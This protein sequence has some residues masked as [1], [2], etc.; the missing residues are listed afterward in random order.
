MARTTKKVDDPVKANQHESYKTFSII[1][2]VIPLVGFILGIVYLT[3]DKKL[4]KKL[5]EHLLVLSIVFSFIWWFLL[6]T[7]VYK[8]VTTSVPV[9]TTSSKE[10]SAKTTPV[11]TPSTV[12][13][14]SI[15]KLGGD[16][17]LSVT[18]QQ[19]VDPASSGNQYITP[20]SGKRFVAVMLQITNN[21]HNSYSDDAYLN[22]KLIGTDNQ[23]A[24][25]S[26]FP[27]SECTNF[28]NGS[29]TLSSGSS[30]TGCIP[31]QLTDGVNVAKV[32][33]Q[34]NG[35]FYGD[36]AEWLAP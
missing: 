33:F 13:V 1:S 25:I 2:I 5:G 4:D 30:V 19:I 28:S 20:D 16:S 29:Y 34:A 11:A 12:H 18:L 7:L 35:G 10:N 9:V 6:A 22:V 27:V 26:M 23:N 21:S 32:Q 15:I 17:G 14:G 24:T 36:T 8:P 31:F 3:K